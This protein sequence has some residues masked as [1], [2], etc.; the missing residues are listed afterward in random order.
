MAAG[1]NK[2]KLGVRR[3]VSLETE[4]ND[5]PAP[6][7]SVIVPT[8]NRRALLLTMLDSLAKLQVKAGEMEV[9]VADDGSTDG[10]LEALGRRRDPF[11]LRVLPA[12]T[13]LGP[14]AARNRGAAAAQGGVLGFLDSDVLVHPTWWQAAQ[15]HF[16]DPQVAAVEGATYAPEGSPAPTPFTHV[17]S[18]RRGGS[19]QT[20]NFLCRRLVFLNLGGFDDRF[21]WRDEH[22]RLWHIREDTDLAF[23][24]LES[25]ALIR[26]EPRALVWHPLVQGKADMFFNKAY[27]IFREALLRRKHP[28]LYARQLS[29]ID[30]QAFPV[31]FWGIYFGLP[32]CLL[33][34]WVSMAAVVFFGALL[35]L[36]GWSGALYAV[37]RKRRPSVRDLLI[38]VPQFLLV[39]WVQL[40]WT[41]RGEWKFRQVHAISASLK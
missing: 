41:L 35:W 30:G 21:C 3:A 2:E 10:T 14:S 9:I 1:E 36:L 31:F 11:A 5:M 39:P 20:C 38:L 32:L 16:Q 8:Y 19:Y 15:A 34:F 12:E 28:D 4:R 6:V 23:S 24:I 22:N 40:Y 18:N 37:C 27:L 25:G 29:W 7:L 17:V 26:F 33:G 13:S